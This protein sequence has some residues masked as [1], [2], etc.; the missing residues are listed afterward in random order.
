MDRAVALGPRTIADAARTVVA[1]SPSRR[2][3]GNG[4]AVQTAG[5]RVCE[6]GHGIAGERDLDG[7]VP[8]GRVVQAEL[9]IIVTTQL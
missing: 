3:R 9:T 6:R 4:E 7:G 5:R 2:V 1:P 8:I